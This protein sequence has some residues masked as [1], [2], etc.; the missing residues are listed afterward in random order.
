MDPGLPPRSKISFRRDASRKTQLFGNR[1]RSVHRI[2]ADRAGG[3][4]ARCNPHRA[5]AA[6]RQWRGVQRKLTAGG[7]DE[8]RS[9]RRVDETE[10]AGDAQPRRKPELGWDADE[11][12]R[13][14]RDK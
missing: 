7:P 12:A 5:D 2:R 4:N 3:K 10:L 13:L 6:P 14:R 9:G 8:N 11:L 1:R